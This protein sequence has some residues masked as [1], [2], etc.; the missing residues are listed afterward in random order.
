MVYSSNTRVGAT[1]TRSVHIASVPSYTSI[2]PVSSGVVFSQ[3]NLFWQSQVSH[4]LVSQAGIYLGQSM[5]AI[6]CGEHLYSD[7]GPSILKV[8]EASLHLYWLWKIWRI[9]GPG[10]GGM[11]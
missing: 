7:R 4:A 10:H 8:S 6:S 9:V 3:G 1:V 11:S 2:S 5:V